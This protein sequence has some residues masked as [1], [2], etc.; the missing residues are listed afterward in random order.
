[1]CGARFFTV[2]FSLFAASFTAF[3]LPENLI[4]FAACIFLAVGASSLP[5]LSKYKHSEVLQ[6]L[7]AVLFFGGCGIFCGVLILAY[8]ISP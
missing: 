6:N 4:V 8:F 1:M 7:S 5:F 2:G 3:L